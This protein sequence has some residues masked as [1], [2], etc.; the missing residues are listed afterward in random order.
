[1]LI[2]LLCWEFVYKDPLLQFVK[3]VQ[4]L[5]GFEIWLL[6]CLEFFVRRLF[7]FLQTDKINNIEF[8][9]FPASQKYKKS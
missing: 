6:Y 4:L 3:G 8:Q 2:Y 1:M 9:T 7:W 5:T